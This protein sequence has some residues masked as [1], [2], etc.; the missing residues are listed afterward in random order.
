MPNKERKER[1]RFTLAQKLEYAK[2]MVD[3]DY[4]NQHVM[5]LSGAGSSAVTWWKKQY[6]AEKAGDVGSGKTPLDPDK[7]RIRAL[8]KQL[9]D[10]KMDVALLKKATA[11][12]IRD[13]PRLK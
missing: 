3:E 11:F 10:S 8:E 7:R 1:S 2:L 12:F 5:A 4:S 13:N 6:L 9:A